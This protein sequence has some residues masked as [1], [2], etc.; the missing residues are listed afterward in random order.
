MKRFLFLLSFKS[1][2]VFGQI[3]SPGLGKQASAAWLAVGLKEDLDTSSRI[4]SVTYLGIGRESKNTEAIPFKH[5]GIFVINQEF[6]D[7]FKKHWQY[8]VAASYRKQ[9]EYQSKAPYDKANPAFKQELRIYGRFMYLQ[10]WSRVKLAL[11]LRQ[12]FRKFYEP[13][14]DPWI[15]NTQLRT[16]LKAQ[17]KI[18]LTA[19]KKHRITLGSEILL[20]KSRISSPEMHWTPL[21]YS[22]TRFTCFYS[23]APKNSFLIY[24]IGYMD[25]VVDEENISYLTFDIIFKNPFGISKRLRSRSVEY[26][27]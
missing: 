5:Q 9:N 18:Y 8:S 11:V 22:E 10:Q 21:K 19:N 12:E 1:L 2:L 17:A 7:H 23:F 27:E 20:T 15:E 14:F 16:R 3:S 25:D 6:Y 26:G 24:S 4:Q 13:G